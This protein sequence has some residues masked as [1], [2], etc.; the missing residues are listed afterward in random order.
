MFTLKDFWDFW[1]GK[2]PPVRVNIARSDDLHEASATRGTLIIGDPGSGKT[3]Y[4]AMQI[5]KRWKASPH[6]VFVFDW[7]GGITNCILELLSKD[8][9]HEDLLEKVILDELGNNEITIPKPEFHPSYGL[10]DEEQVARVIDNMDYLATYLSE[11]AS[12]VTG[13]SIREIGKHLLRILQ[14]IKNEHDESWQITE[15]LDLI[16]D[17][18]MLRRACTKYGQYALPSKRYFERQYLP[19]DIMPPHE[20][21]L[22]TTALRTLLG[23]IDGRIPR[24]TLGYYKP[25]YTPKEVDENNLLSLV[26]AHQMINT[27]A[28]QHYLLAQSFSH[29]MTWINKREVDDPKNKL[30]E[31]DFDETVSILKIPGFAEKLGSVS[32]LYRS[33]KVSLMIIIQALWQ[34]DENLRE[35]IWNLANV[36]SFT[37]SNIKDAEAISQ[38]LLNYDPKFV[39][40]YA[41]TAVQNNT[42][43]P[44]GGQTRI[45]ADWLQNLKAREFIMRRYITEQTRE[46]GVQYVQRTDDFPSGPSYISVPEIKKE[47]MRRRGVPIR[48]A[49]EIVKDRSTLLDLDK[50]DPNF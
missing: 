43:E 21:Q 36:V 32:P 11:T 42:T 46:K 45:A 25:G 34:L 41:K 47:L 22:L 4:A 50:S 24:A 40:N 37:V 19:K 13:V 44:E 26:D 27:P 23:T 8:K 15:A 20:K 39:K 49:L 17:Q 2:D 28:A 30:A 38:Q 33:R 31:I 5:V 12:F 1:Y 35:Q 14:V 48:D 18:N 3:R 10:T 6:P 9:D 16:T 7:S 29:V